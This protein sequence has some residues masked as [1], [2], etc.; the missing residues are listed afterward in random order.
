MNSYAADQPFQVTR[1]RH[2]RVRFPSW[3]KAGIFA[4]GLFVAWASIG[5]ARLGLPEATGPHAV[6][7]YQETWLTSAGP[8]PLQVWYPAQ[9]GSG[10]AGAY[11]ENLDTISADLAQ[12][13]GLN[14]LV[15]WALGFVRNESLFDATPIETSGLPLLILSPGNQTNAVFYSAFAEDLA[16]SGY[17]VLG[18]DHPGQVGAV[19]M[20]NGEVIGYDSSLD[21]PGSAVAK[22]ERRVEEIS[23]AIDRVLES[24]ARALIAPIDPTRIGVL[25]HS[26]GGLAA[27]EV[28]RVDSRVK[29]CAN[30]DGEAAGGPFGV[31]MDSH[32]PLQPFLYLTKEAQ[33]HP[34]IAGRFESKG[35]IRVVVP[36]AQHDDFTDGALFEAAL[37]P[38]NRRTRRVS[39]VSRG[40]VKSF[41][42]QAL[43][44]SD[45]WDF[46][47]LVAGTDIYINVFPLGEQPLIP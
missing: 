39:E 34:E 2:R 7:R 28:C 41:F 25:G 40:V 46:A 14:S 16:S 23:S 6:G 43:A 1:F 9:E 5:L 15:T 21:V 13:G 22:V 36:A 33:I 44:G 11:V 17:I 12:S 32:P 27:A 24:P 10:R 31:N 29:A 37:N 42:A 3:K 30:I 18:I 20:P 4:L 45:S 19:E 38:I 26:L 35:K 8:I 47:G